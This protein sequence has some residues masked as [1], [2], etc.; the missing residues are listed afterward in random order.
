M[1]ARRRGASIIRALGSF[2]PGHVVMPGPG[3]SGHGPRGYT[4]DQPVIAPEVETL[5][6]PETGGA[7]RAMNTEAPFTPFSPSPPLRLY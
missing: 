4:P 3:S 5:F 7:G 1:W 6:T 2:G